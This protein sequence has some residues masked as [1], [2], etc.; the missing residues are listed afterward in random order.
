MCA[1][2]HKL[3]LLTSRPVRAHLPTEKVFVYVCV[4]AFTLHDKK[5]G[6]LIG[7]P[8][9]YCVSARFLFLLVIKIDWEKFTG[10]FTEGNVLAHSENADDFTRRISV[11]SEVE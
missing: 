7:L 9:V 11:G 1:R 10:V 2:V 6:N 4:R 5:N 8:S 3:R